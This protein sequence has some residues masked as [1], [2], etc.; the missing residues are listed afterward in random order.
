MANDNNKKL[1][2][3]KQAILDYIQSLSTSNE[4]CSDYM[5]RKYVERGMPARY[6]DNHWLAHKDNID[7]FFK[8]FTKVTMRG[9]PIQD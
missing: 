3:N 1:L 9:A 8:N 2:T 5:F 4:V 7:E 6:E